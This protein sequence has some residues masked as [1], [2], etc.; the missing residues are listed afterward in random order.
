METTILNTRHPH[1]VRFGCT[2]STLM[3]TGKI[4]D[5]YYHYT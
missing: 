5:G 3:P 4:A 2:L 1:D